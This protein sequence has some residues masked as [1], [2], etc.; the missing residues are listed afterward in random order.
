[1]NLIIEKDK[2]AIKNVAKKYEW[3]D[4]DSYFYYQINDLK[5]REI[6]RFKLTE[7]KSSKSI[8]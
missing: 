4:K 5:K 6:L 3:M 7:L 8:V 2:R 1:M